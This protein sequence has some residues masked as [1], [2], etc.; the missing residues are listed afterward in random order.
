MATLASKL[1]K[2]FTDKF[3]GAE[4]SVNRYP[5]SKKV[6][7]TVVWEGFDEIEPIDRQTL[8][9]QAIREGL[10]SEELKNVTL[11]TTFTPLEMSEIVRSRQSA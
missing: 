7:A 1:K 2:V 8:V 6:G 11:V 9:R 3:N 4:V 5:E 10:S